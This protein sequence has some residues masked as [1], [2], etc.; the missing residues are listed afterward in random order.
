MTNLRSLDAVDHPLFANE[1]LLPCQWAPRRLSPVRPETRLLLAILRSGIIEYRLY[2]DNPQAWARHLCAEFRL[3]VR[4]ADAPFT[5]DRCC[6]EL[7]LDPVAV[8]EKILSE[9]V[10]RQR[11]MSVIRR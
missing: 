6:C 11:V 4:G 10:H 7:G 5:F 1:N 8:R 9:K 3:W 2:R